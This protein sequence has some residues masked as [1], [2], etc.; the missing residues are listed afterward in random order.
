[1]RIVHVIHT[2]PPFSRAGSENYCEALAF[3]QAANHEV[4]VFHRVAD[5]DQ[6][7]YEVTEDRLGEL[8]VARL[9][10]TFRDAT[11]FEDTYRSEA[12]AAAFGVY[13][14]RFQP[15][16]VHFHHVTCLSTSCV[17]AAK[18]RGILVVYTLHDFWLLCPRGQLL[19]RDLS[20][21]ERHSDADCVRCM[22]YQLP[23][24]GGH[25][26]VGELYERAIELGRHGFPESIHRW[27]ASRPFGQ[28][29]AA[30]T[31][32]R[33]R[34]H[35]ILEMCGM[36]DRFIAPLNFL[37]DR[38]VE[39]GIPEEKITVSDYG[40]D[41]SA[42][43]D[44]PTTPAVPRSED[45]SDRL[46]VVYLGTWIPSKGVDVLLEA[47]K[48]LDPSRAVLDVHGYG[49][50][51]DG[52]DDYEAQLR[53]LAADAPHIRLRERYDPEAV[54]TLLAEAAALVVPSIW[55]ENSPLTIHE[56]FLAGVPVI[57]S[58]HGGMKELVRHGIN[59]LNFRPA[60]AASLRR[61]LNRLSEDRGLLVK[62]REGIPPVKSIADNAV[63][64]D[65]L[66]R[67]LLGSGALTGASG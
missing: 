39:F 43:Q 62:L 66:Y 13:L 29:Q 45:T 64:I 36:V 46:R 55:Y 63:E 35:H 67:N 14:D 7:E 51:Y 32:I 30:M 23:I 12:A 57:A 42:W 33:A 50:P 65:A 16:V 27:L 25:E 54:P 60:D 4:A 26:R 3:E 47:F 38:Y 1:M 10:R 22:A 40:F 19:R 37:R 2:F 44:R 21:C 15:D 34:T 8:P 59:G 18:E 61:T 5:G 56:A 28:E 41:L 48:G 17:H 31:Q 20:L 49:M 58:G 53:S 9:N 6:P 24:E 52:V 11:G